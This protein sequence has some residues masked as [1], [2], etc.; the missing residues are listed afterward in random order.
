MYQDCTC[1]ALPFPALQHAVR[2]PLRRTR[3]EAHT[4]AERSPF[5]LTRHSMDGWH[6]GESNAL[7]AARNYWALPSG[8]SWDARTPCGWAPSVSA[9]MAW[10]LGGSCRPARRK[11]TLASAMAAACVA[12]RDGAARMGTSCQQSLAMGNTSMRPSTTDQVYAGELRT[13]PLAAV[14]ELRIVHVLMAPL[15]LP[16]FT[17]NGKALEHS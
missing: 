2:V 9:A 1:L 3:L 8:E 4:I 11:G 15:C 14:Q 16:S 6:A 5:A 10:R 13:C 17:S 12:A 7:L